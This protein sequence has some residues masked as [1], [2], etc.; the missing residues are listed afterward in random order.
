MHLSDCVL[1]SFRVATDGN[2]TRAAVAAGY[3]IGN[4]AVFALEALVYRCASVSFGTSE[5]TVS[6]WLA[7]GLTPV[8][9]PANVTRENGNYYALWPVTSN[10]TV[11]AFLQKAGW[12]AQVAS[13]NLSGGPAAQGLTVEEDGEV[14]FELQ[15]AGEPLVDGGDVPFDV[16]FHGDRAYVDAQEV[17]TEPG[18]D[19]RGGTIRGVSGPFAAALVLPVQA[20]FVPARMVANETWTLGGQAGQA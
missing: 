8:L 13:F 6:A 7:V 1:D 20:M 9:P 11:A 14:L 16:R 18:L 15:Q 4:D 5:N 3:D 12:A 2:R 19:P 17:W 10:A